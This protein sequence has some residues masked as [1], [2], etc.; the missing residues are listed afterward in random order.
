MAREGA[1]RAGSL[2]DKEQ[3]SDRQQTELDLHGV[4][5]RA[6]G[7]SAHGDIRSQCRPKA[8]RKNPV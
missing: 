1:L 5:L 8:T 3:E 6:N 2:A 4:F 7:L